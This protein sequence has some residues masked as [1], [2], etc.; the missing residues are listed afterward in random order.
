MG[1]AEQAGVV[2][3]RVWGGGRGGLGLLW[4]QG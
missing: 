4:F 3:E 1:Q 2:L